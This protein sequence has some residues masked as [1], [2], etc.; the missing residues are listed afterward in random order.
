MQSVWPGVTFETLPW[1]R[2]DTDLASRRQ[3]RLADGPYSAALVPE[4][5]RRALALPTELLAELEDAAAELTRFDAEQGEFQAPFAAILLRTESTSSSEIENLTVSAKQLALAELGSAKSPNANLVLANVHAMQAALGLANEVTAR[6]IIQMHQALL[7]NIIPEK[8]GRWR[9][10]QVWIGGGSFSPH[11][12]DFVPPNFERVP[13]AIN[14]LIAFM[15]RD[16]LPVLAQIAISHAQF[17]TIHPFTDGNGRTGRAL[18]QAMLRG[19]G[20]TRGALV[21]LSAGLLH[22]TKSYFAALDKYREGELR[23]IIQVFIDATYGAIQNGRALKQDLAD[24]STRWEQSLQ[25]RSDSVAHRLRGYL[26]QQPVIS[27][28]QTVEVFGVTAPVA[29]VAIEKLV[30]IGALQKTSENRRNR[31]WQATE[32]LAALEAFAQRARRL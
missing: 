12:A 18:I 22:N 10:E 5:S 2:G 6:A 4:I 23:P 17:E 30:A 32:V 7:G 25:A 1:S 13:S 8:V 28:A 15:E 24:I 9:Q 31:T 16:D 20:L 11:T 21:P 14:D 27:I 26:L 3:M 19:K 29:L